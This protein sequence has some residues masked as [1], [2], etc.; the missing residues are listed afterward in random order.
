MALID[1]IEMLGAGVDDGIIDRDDA[2]ALLVQYADGGLTT[3]SALWTLDNHRGM[4]ARGENA[5]ADIGA[6][7]EAMRAVRA[8]A[9]PE[10]YLV[11]HD[12]MLAEAARQRAALLEREKARL[13][14]DLRHGRGIFGVRPENLPGDED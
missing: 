14:D 5:I 7:V 1:R 11:A 12:A 2:A 3:V 8:A 10:E 13:R 6:A 9:T 4:R